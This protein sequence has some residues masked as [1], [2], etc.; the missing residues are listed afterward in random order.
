MGIPIA[1]A[2]ALA[3]S[4]TVLRVVIGLFAAGLIFMLLVLA[5]LAVIPFAASGSLVVTSTSTVTTDGPVVKGEW[6]YPLKGAYSTGRGFGYNP[7]SGCSYC[8]TNHK[9]YDM[10]QACESTVYAVGPGSVV[11]AGSY[12]GWGNAVM[13]DHGNGV[14]TLYGHMLWDS[15]RVGIGDEVTA[16]T[17]L[18]A[19]GNTGQSF[20]CHLHFEV[21]TSGVAIDPEP[22]MAALGL[23]LR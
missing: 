9:G 1:A 18:G 17:P 20:G 23:P 22:F 13:I 4:R 6:G 19:E 7:V 3:K 8:S 12:F 15:L 14:Q 5:P 10:S 16:G 11:V 2:A 21:R